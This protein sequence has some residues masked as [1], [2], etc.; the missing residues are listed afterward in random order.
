MTKDGVILGR[1]LEYGMSVSKMTHG[2]AIIG[3]GSTKHF[4][5]S[6]KAFILTYLKGGNL[7]GGIINGTMMEYFPHPL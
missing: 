6:I 1:R 4:K 2:D 7:A 5:V 3:N